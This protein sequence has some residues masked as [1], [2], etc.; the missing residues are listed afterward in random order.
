VSREHLVLAF[1]CYT[2]CDTVAHT[3]CNTFLR[4]SLPNPHTFTLKGGIRKNRISQD[5]SIYENTNEAHT[6]KEKEV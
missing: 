2:F 1:L 5:Y 3:N 4:Y 6:K